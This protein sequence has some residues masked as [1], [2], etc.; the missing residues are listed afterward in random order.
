MPE[1]GPYQRADRVKPQ[2]SAQ[3][4][5]LLLFSYPIAIDCK[6]DASHMLAWPIMFA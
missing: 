2:L 6:A 3:E 4:D 5:W 1:V